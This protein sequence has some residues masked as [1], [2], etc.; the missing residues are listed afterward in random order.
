MGVIGLGGASRRVE[1]LP[2][3]AGRVAEGLC[4]VKRRMEHS[5]ELER[6]CCA[7]YNWV[8]V[9]SCRALYVHRLFD[10]RGV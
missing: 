7:L 8:D 2:A 4:R 5:R 3:A 1:L 9:V 6:E 10:S